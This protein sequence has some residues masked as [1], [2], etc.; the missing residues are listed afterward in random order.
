MTHEKKSMN[1]KDI[2]IEVI[3]WLGALMILV[4]FALNG[5]EILQSQSYAYQLL[6]LVGAL[7]VVVT[8]LHR[9]VHQTALL[10]GFWAV[11]AVFALINVVLGA[12]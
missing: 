7:G 4:G 10:N 12:N 9:K 2:A 6:N 5:F 3:G 8:S 11:I 1:K